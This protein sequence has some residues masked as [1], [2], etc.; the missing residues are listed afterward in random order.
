MDAT[1]FQDMYPEDY[2]HCFGC[3]RNNESGLHLKS[4]WQG[5]ESICHHTPKEYYSGGFPGFLY[6]GMI[7]SLM[8]CHGA[9]TASAAKAK[10]EGGSPQRF[11]TATITVNFARPTPLGVELEV[12][13]K[14]TEIS[15]RKVFVNLSL[16]ANGEVCATGHGLFILIPQQT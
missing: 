1:P 9:A 16:S 7:T 2:A 4:Y 5:E 3:G 14:V 6:G 10:A 11:V 12:R 8:D 15:G 13:G